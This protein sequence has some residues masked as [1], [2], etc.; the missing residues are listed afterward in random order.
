MSEAEK[1]FRRKNRDRT[2]ARLAV[3]IF[4]GLPLALLL[5]TCIGSIVK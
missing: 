1:Y 3:L 2:G 5:G 4:F